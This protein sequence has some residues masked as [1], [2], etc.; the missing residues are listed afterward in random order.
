MRA[1]N[2][3]FVALF[4]AGL[5]SQ[6]CSD[7][8]SRSDGGS[9]VPG[10]P[11]CTTLAAGIDLALTEADLM[12]GRTISSL[13]FVYAR[14]LW[15]RTRVPSLP[16]IAEVALTFINPRGEISYE[17]RTPYSSDPDVKE[18]TSTLGH[19]ITV[20]PAKS[21][22]GGFALDR[23]IPI[24]GSVLQR[25]PAPEGIWEIQS[26]VDGYAEKLST[27]LDVTNQR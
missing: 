6:G 3:V 2:L 20:F 8:K 22:P 5:L 24:A 16:R 18:T 14:D 27:Q 25:I 17:D 13:N 11:G 7:T 21:I 4:V 9:C 15:V 1:S 23:P 10:E 26:V 12:Q 19:P